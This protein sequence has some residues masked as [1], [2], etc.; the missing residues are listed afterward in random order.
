MLSVLETQT[1]AIRVL[2]PTGALCEPDVAPFRQRMLEAVDK[3]LGRFVV[4]L[5]AVPFIDSKGLESLVDATQALSQLGQ[6]LRLCAVGKTVREVMELTGI[7]EQ[8]EIYDDSHGAVR[9]FLS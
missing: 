6:S 8:F 7:A 9:S 3:H 2:R 4:D 1:G 5:S